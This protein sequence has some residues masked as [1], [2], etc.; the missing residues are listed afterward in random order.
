L[1]R[2]EVRSLNDEVSSL[3]DRERATQETMGSLRDTVHG[4]QMEML[5]KERQLLKLRNKEEELE[6][7]V[8]KRSTNAASLSALLEETTQKLAAQELLVRS[9]EEVI[10]KGDREKE[11][12]L[13]SH[14]Y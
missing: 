9:L 7:M 4:L 11:D 6:N 3:S 2:G 1:L 8:K 12:T 5:E 13:E 10:E 14:R